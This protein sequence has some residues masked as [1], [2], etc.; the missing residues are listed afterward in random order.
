MKTRNLLTLTAIAL[1]VAIGLSSCNSSTNLPDETLNPAEKVVKAQKKHD[2]AILL[3]TFGSTF[4]KPIETYDKVIAD[5][6]AAFPDADIYLSFTSRTCVNRV[7]KETGIDRYQPD[8]WLEALGNAGYKKVAVQSLHVIPGE[9]YL[10]LMNTDVKKNFMIK[11]FPQVKVLKSACLLDN[12]EDVDAVAEIL[13]DY[14]KSVLASKKDVM[15][16]MGHGNPD[17]NYNANGKYGDVEKAMNALTTNKN[18]IVGTVDHGPM[19]FFPEEGEANTECVYSKLLTYCAANDLKPSDVT[20]HMVPLMSIAGD[21]AHNDMWGIDEGDDYSKATPGADACWRLKVLKMG[22][23]LD[24]KESHTGANG[25][26]AILGLGDHAGIRKVWL[27]HMISQ[28]NDAAS[29]TT[30]QDY[31]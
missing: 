16:F 30:G 20:V 27:N 24:M 15:L 1:A 19:L 21:H 22:F 3:C 12:Q 14:Y 25:Q 5:Y 4:K 6:E 26:S 13:Y 2:T 28:Y 7:L 11:G 8:L 29:W 17:K 23:K 10:S 31:Q 9:E 18:V